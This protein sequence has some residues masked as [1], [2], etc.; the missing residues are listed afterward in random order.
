MLHVSVQQVKYLTST[1]KFRAHEIAYFPNFLH[2]TNSKQLMDGLDNWP[3]HSQET[4]FKL[5]LISSPTQWAYRCQL[6]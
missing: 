5:N 6:Q 3:P 2:E 4:A 1:F